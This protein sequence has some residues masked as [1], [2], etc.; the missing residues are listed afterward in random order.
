MMKLNLKKTIW[1]IISDLRMMKLVWTMSL[2]K[3]QIFLRK[4]RRNLLQQMNG[5]FEMVKNLLHLSTPNF[6]WGKNRTTRWYLEP[7]AAQS[8]LTPRHNI[9]PIFHRP[10]P[11]GNVKNANDPES[12]FWCIIDDEIIA[13]TVEYTNI[14]IEKVRPQFTRERDAKPTDIRGIYAFLDWN[15]LFSWSHK[16]K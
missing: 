8:S 11:K 9:I 1:N 4:K 14:Y 2:M 13:K 10:G 15:S 16:G 12:A 3:Y 5:P 7:Q 6:I